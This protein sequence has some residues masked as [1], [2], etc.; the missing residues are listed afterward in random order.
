VE[1]P[2]AEMVLPRGRK[3]RRE[4][5]LLLEA[6]PPTAFSLAVNSLLSILNWTLGA[7][8]TLQTLENMLYSIQAILRKKQSQYLKERV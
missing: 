5:L 4:S 7:L 3:K 6:L 2:A 1:N 8:P